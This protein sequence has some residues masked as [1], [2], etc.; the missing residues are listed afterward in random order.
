[1]VKI[2]WESPENVETKRCFPPKKKSTTTTFTNLKT[3]PKSNKRKSKTHHYRPIERDSIEGGS[4]GM[5]A[6]RGVVDGTAS[7][8][9]WHGVVDGTKLGDVAWWSV[10]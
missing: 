2:K 5:V 3:H 8:V 7:S 9:M 10:W 1:M 6:W 4:N